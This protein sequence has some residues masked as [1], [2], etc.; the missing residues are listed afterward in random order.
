MPK[1]TRTQLVTYLHHVCYSLPHLAQTVLIWPRQFSFGPCFFNLAHTLAQTKN[2][3]EGTLKFR[4]EHIEFSLQIRIALAKISKQRVSEFNYLK[5]LQAKSVI[6]WHI[7]H[8]PNTVWTFALYINLITLL[9]FKMCIL[10]AFRIIFFRLCT[11]VLHP[12][13]NNYCT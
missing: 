13:F 9:H 7:Y 8:K 4:M 6:L 12:H 2:E 11:W 1:I 10:F 5:P 3:P